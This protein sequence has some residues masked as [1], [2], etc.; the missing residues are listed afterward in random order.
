[1][2]LVPFLFMRTSGGFTIDH[3]SKCAGKDHEYEDQEDEWWHIVILY[4]L[5][6]VS[7]TR[8]AFYRREIG[9]WLVF[10]TLPAI[11]DISDRSSGSH[12]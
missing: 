12:R 4:L 10:H 9:I 3:V 8:L 7:D 11:P 6:Y 5:M 2:V 1:M